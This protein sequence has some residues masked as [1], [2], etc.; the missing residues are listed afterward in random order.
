M[1][2]SMFTRLIECSRVQSAVI[3]YT[4]IISVRSAVKEYVVNAAGLSR[5]GVPGQVTIA[6][7]PQPK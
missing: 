4:S 1:N 7:E 6:F 2:F 5:N 3:D